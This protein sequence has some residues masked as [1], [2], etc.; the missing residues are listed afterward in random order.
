MINCNTSLRSS[1]SASQ[2]PTPHSGVWC[3]RHFATPATRC[4]AS[5]FQVLQHE[6]TLLI[7]SKLT[8]PWLSS[9]SIA[10]THASR[11]PPV[12][13]AINPSRPTPGFE[14][15][16]ERG[17]ANVP[18]Q[19]FIQPRIEILEN[20][21][22]RRMKHTDRTGGIPSSRRSPSCTPTAPTRRF[23]LAA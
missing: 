21:H 2:H 10:A 16:P 7:S 6:L 14:T 8:S 1:K 13:S 11:S 19:P 4:S 23:F 5:P 15:S 3:C 9:P 12:G 22:A 17:A 20:S 18:T